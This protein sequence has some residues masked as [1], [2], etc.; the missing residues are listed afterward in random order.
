[1]WGW[2]K[3][4]SHHNLGKEHPFAS[5]SF[6][7][8]DMFK[9]SPDYGDGGILVPSI[10]TASSLQIFII[11]EHTNIDLLSQTGQWRCEKH[12]SAEFSVKVS[13]PTA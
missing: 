2:V 6:D 13:D 1:M 8:L 3:T 5:Y 9:C 4:F 11:P 10:L 12:D 7:G